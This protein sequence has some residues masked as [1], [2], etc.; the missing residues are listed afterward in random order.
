MI[1]ERLKLARQVCKDRSSELIIIVIIISSKVQ[2][3][4]T[5][6]MQQHPSTS[7]K[8]QQHQST[9]IKKR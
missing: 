1:A 9:S 7:I 8:M 5:E 2:A 3:L 4:H 6:T